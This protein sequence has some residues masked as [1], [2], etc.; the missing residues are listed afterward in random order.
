M[1][2]ETLV[3]SARNA[4]QTILL[5]VQEE[6]RKWEADGKDAWSALKRLG[7][8]DLPRGDEVILAR[9]LYREFPRLKSELK[10]QGIKLG[11]FCEDAGLGAAGNYSKE[12]H[13]MMLA[14]D[15]QSARVRV[16]R[17][18]SKYRWLLEAMARVFN[19]SCSALAHQL[20]SGMSLHPANAEVREEAEE[21]Q[22]MLQG[23][24]NRVDQ[25]FGLFSLFMETAAL[26]AKHAAEGGSC[27]WPQFEAELRASAF[28][29]P[30]AS[31]SEDQIQE[32]LER[33]FSHEPVPWETPRRTFEEERA[34]DVMARAAEREAAMDPT[35]AYWQEAVTKRSSA[36][37]VWLYGPTPSGCMMDDEFFYVPHVYLGYGEGVIN[38]ID[39]TLGYGEHA[40]AVEK[41]RDDS[42]LA[43]E[44]YGPAPDDDW[45]EVAQR[46]RGQTSSMD[47]AMARYHAWLIAYPS[48]DNSCLMPMLL[49]PVE[50]C[51]PVLIPLD[52]VTLAALRDAFWVAPDGEVE[53]FL[54]RIKRLIGY[55]PGQPKVI[56]EG[57][58]RTA[59]WLKR[60]PFMKMKEERARERE[61]VRQFHRG[62]ELQG[63]ERCIDDQQTTP[64]HSKSERPQQ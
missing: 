38:P 5:R 12:L 43:F 19:V 14:P 44:K 16:R 61:Y 36:H 33:Y 13:R 18:A 20:M 29:P 37:G 31:L 6:S 58:R 63:A 53:E 21:V 2:K 25:E 62:L 57:L 32:N 51:G 11:R 10:R 55:L 48:P 52:V 54:V 64:Y 1:T 27:R 46:P 22:G 50:E 60:N 7:A 9:S 3:S 30:A 40:V 56:L 17:S 45:D 28:E 41:L 4:V 42:L 47:D 59:P 24:V 39:S 8:K 35:R 26:K 49:V 34:A 23:L 15:A